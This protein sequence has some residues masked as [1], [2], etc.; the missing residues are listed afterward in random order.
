MSIHNEERDKGE[1]HTDL[2]VEW[3][4]VKTLTPQQLLQESFDACDGG[5]G[6]EVFTA[7]HENSNNFIVDILINHFP[8]VIVTVDTREANAVL[9][10]SNQRNPVGGREEITI[11]KEWTEALED[12]LIEAYGL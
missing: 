2:I 9:F 3:E 12:Y 4:R 7:L 5:D 10:V 6:I 8:T 11:D 1:C